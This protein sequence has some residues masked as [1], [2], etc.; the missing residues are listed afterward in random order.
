MIGGI[1][2]IPVGSD[3][4]KALSEALDKKANGD[5]GP[6][7]KGTEARVLIDAFK[8]IRRSNPFTV[9]ALVMVNNYGAQ[10]YKFANGEPVLVIETYAPR[11]DSVPGSNASFDCNDMDVFVRRCG[12]YIRLAVES[13]RFTHYTGPIEPVPDA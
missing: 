5:D 1:M 13:W 10:R 12:D 7:D 3:L 9:G 11:S 2:S 6:K 8:D 4:G